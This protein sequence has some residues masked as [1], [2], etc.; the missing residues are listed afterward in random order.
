[1][2]PTWLTIGGITFLVALLSNRLQATPDFRWFLKQRRPQWLTFEWAIPLIWIFILSCGAFS[3]A[4]VW[5]I[6]HSGGLMAGYLFLE[7][8]ILSYTLVMCRL[9]SLRI[10]T[11]IGGIGFLIG[12]LLA[13]AVWPVSSNAVSLLLPYLLWSPIGTFVT[14]QMI[15][16]NPSDR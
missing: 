9:R 14:W 16:L 4:L 11:L 10:G 13:V 3:A 1:M 6:S 8:V 15:R 5:D 7:M 12:C 2:I